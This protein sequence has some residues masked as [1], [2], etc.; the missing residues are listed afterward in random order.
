MTPFSQASALPEDWTAVSINPK[1][2]RVVGAFT[3]VLDRH[4]EQHRLHRAVQHRVPAA[5]APA[6]TST[7]S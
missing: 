7:C 6:R 2:G 5:G 4:A 3:T 1:T